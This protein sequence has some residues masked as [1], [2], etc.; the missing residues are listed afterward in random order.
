MKIKQ[1][2]LVSILS[3]FTYSMAFANDGFSAQYNGILTDIYKMI[4]NPDLDN[5]DDDFPVGILEAVM[6]GDK[7]DN[8]KSIGYYVGDITDDGIPELIVGTIPDFDFISK[9]D[10]ES[11]PFICKGNDIYLIM[12]LKDGKPVTVKEGS[13]RNQICTLPDNTFINGG[14]GGYAY[15][16]RGKFTL[17]KDG[18]QLSWSDYYFSEPADQESDKINVYYNKTGESKSSSSQKVS[19]TFD[20]LYNLWKDWVSQS[21]PLANPLVKF[22]D[23][24]PF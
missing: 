17:G 18:T 16:I 15:I 8:L 3:S 4:N 21:K 5:V 10:E 12:S 9:L 19:M 6:N 20:D 24:K 2:L 14:S 23:F 1:L 22:E 13:A 11:Q 7:N